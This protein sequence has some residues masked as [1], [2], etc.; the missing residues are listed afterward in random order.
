MGMD[1]DFEIMAKK[2]QEYSGSR[3]QLDEI[4]G[5]ILQVDSICSQACLELREEYK[6][7]EKNRK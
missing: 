7:I 5:L 4:E 1:K 3:K 2:I 6:L